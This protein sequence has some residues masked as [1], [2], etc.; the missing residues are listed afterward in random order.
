MSCACNRMLSHVT[1]HMHVITCCHM[2]HVICMLSHVTCHMHV[3]TC[4]HM[5]HACHSQAVINLLNVLSSFPALYEVFSK[6]TPTS[7]PHSNPITVS[8]STCMFACTCMCMVCGVVQ[9]LFDRLVLVN[10]PHKRRVLL[11]FEEDHLF[12]L[13]YCKHTCMYIHM[14]MCTHV[15]TQVDYTYYVSILVIHI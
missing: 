10:T 12:G 4:C 14:Y 7:S 6:A 2:S 8:V 5:S 3:I 1:C 9:D 13:R 15:H 11:N